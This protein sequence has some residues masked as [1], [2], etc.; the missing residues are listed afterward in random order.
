M[1]LSSWLR[2]TARVHLVHLVHADKRPVA[3]NPQTEP[4]DLDCL[5]A[6]HINRCHLLLLLSQKADHSDGNGVISGK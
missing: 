4:T 5:A 3:T 6:A 1:V 2:A